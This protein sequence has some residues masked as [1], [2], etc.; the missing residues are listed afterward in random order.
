MHFYKKKINLQGSYLICS[1][2]F[3]S[4]LTDI[5]ESEINRWLKLATLIIIQIT[6]L[7]YINVTL[8]SRSRSLTKKRA[9]QDIFSCEGAA[10]E[11]LM[12]VCLSVCPSPMLKF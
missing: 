12:S 2:D 6:Y 10:L 8:R 11:V 5:T 7:Q 1:L 3:T 9:C 4:E